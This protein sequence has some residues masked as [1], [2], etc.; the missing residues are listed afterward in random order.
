MG[1][2]NVEIR[3]FTDSA[4]HPNLYVFGLR[5]ALVG[6]ANLTNA[7]ITS[8]QEVMLSITAEDPRFDSLTN[9]YSEYW[10]QS[11]V[12]TSEVLS[13]Y[14]AICKKYENLQQLKGALDGEV[15]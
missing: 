14:Q 13:I 9:L 1:D 2:S 11:A 12:L 5:A 7:A 15:V 6:S 8:N 3:Y 4:F 10:A